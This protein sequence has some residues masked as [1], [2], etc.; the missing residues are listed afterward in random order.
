MPSQHLLSCHLLREGRPRPCLSPAERSNGFDLIGS[1][2]FVRSLAATE[3][4]DRV[5]SDQL[6]AIRTEIGTMM[7]MRL[8]TELVVELIALM[9][10]VAPS[11]PS[12]SKPSAAAFMHAFYSERRS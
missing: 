2:D 1:H 9:D 11:L 6:A 7:D 4:R 3:H 8:V 5:G 10:A 12:G